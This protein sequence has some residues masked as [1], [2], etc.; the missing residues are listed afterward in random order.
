LKQRQCLW[1]IDKF[2]V[3]VVLLFPLSFFSSTNSAE[4]L[5]QRQVNTALGGY[6]SLDFTREQK[7]GGKAGKLYYQKNLYLEFEQKPL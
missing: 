4:R 7:S 3:L 6:G 1:P 2:E 5:K